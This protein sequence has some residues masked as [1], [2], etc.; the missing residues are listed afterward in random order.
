MTLRHSI[1]LTGITALALAADVAGA[2]DTAQHSDSWGAAV[3]DTATT[4]KVKERL[5]DDKRLGSAKIS[6]TTNNG[7]VTLTGSAPSADASNAAEE[8]AEGVKGVKSVDNQ[9]AAPTK[10]HD[11]AAKVSDDWITTRIKTQLFTDRSV[12][13][14]SN[15][16]VSTSQGVV[17]LAGTAVSKDAYDQAK[18]VA[19]NV[20]GVKSV[21]ASALHL[22]SSQ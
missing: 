14:D 12:Q 5:A 10:L 16:S 15:I 17:H 18:S 4:A 19:Q 11:A 7:V 9:I 13:G 2:D 22:A 21:D 3:S 8:T 6:V 20:K 1:L